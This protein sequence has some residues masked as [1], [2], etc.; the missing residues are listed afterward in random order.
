MSDAR[1]D[2]V[3]TSTDDDAPPPGF[4]AR[5]CA[6]GVLVASL[7]LLTVA[8]LLVL[9]GMA[10][11]AAVRGMVEDFQQDRDR[12]HADAQNDAS[13]P[14][15]SRNSYD[16]LHAEL[17][18]TNDSSKR[19]RYLVAVEFLAP[20][21][22]QLDSSYG[23]ASKVDPGETKPIVIDTLTQAPEGPFTCRVDNVDRSADGD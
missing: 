19:S 17:T 10:A 2:L 14:T 22:E 7:A 9:A 1:E 12:E 23:T 5:G 15:C 4:D 18:V 20:D 8:A 21:G 16:D 13:T 11:V 6:A 3:M